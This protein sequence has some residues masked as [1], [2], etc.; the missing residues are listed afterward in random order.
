MKEWRILITPPRRINCD[1]AGEAG[2]GKRVDYALEVPG[3]YM[4]AVCSSTARDFD[5]SRFEK[6]FHT[7][8]VLNY[9][10][11]VQHPTGM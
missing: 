4:V 9:P 5:E 6:H 8:R 3:G 11:P 2:Q 1:K 7:L 10:P